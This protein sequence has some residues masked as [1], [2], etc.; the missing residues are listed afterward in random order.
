MKSL[1]KGDFMKDLKEYIKEYGIKALCIH[2]LDCINGRIT[3]QELKD[4][5]TYR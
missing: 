3:T 1:F 5:I 4:F 2:I